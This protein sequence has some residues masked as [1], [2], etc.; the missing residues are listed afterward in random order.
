MT[1]E[2][3]AAIGA[4]AIVIVSGGLLFTMASI[5]RT[6]KVMRRVVEDV[7]DETVPLLVDVHSGVVQTNQE[8]KRVDG[9]IDRAESIGA[10]VDSTSKLTY[11]LL[12]SPAV[13][14]MALGAGGTRAFRQLRRRKG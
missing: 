7:H 1:G 10:T 11:K 6:M 8:L 9:L 5:I 2:G 3:V 14:V 13:K 12:S 4:V